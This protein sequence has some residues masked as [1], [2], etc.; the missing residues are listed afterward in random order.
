MLSGKAEERLPIL[1]IELINLVV[2]AKSRFDVLGRPAESEIRSTLSMYY[3]QMLALR[4]SPVF[5]RGVAGRGKGQ[6]D[7]TRPNLST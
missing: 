3:Q 2:T 1:P 4:C 6:S 5:V 7:N